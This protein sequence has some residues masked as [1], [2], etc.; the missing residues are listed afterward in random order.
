MPDNNDPNQ[1]GG[2]GDA[3]TSM[4]VGKGGEE[5]AAP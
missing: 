4:R 2:E 1:V 5:V 3:I